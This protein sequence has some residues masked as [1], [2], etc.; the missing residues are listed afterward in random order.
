MTSRLSSDGFTIQF[1]PERGKKLTM[2]TTIK[3]VYEVTK[4]SDLLSR[5]YLLPLRQCGT[6]DGIALTDG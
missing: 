6:A 5:S 1:V 4:P 3:G 2:K